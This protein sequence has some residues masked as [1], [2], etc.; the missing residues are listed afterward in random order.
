MT[1]LTYPLLIGGT[2]GLVVWLGEVLVLETSWCCPQHSPQ[3][4]SLKSSMR[5]TGRAMS[6]PTAAVLTGIISLVAFFISHSVVEVEGT[7]WVEPV[8]LWVSIGITTGSHHFS[9]QVPTQLNQ[10]CTPE[11]LWNTQHLVHVQADSVVTIP[12]YTGMVTVTVTAWW[13]SGITRLHW[14]DQLCP[15]IG[16]RISY[17]SSTFNLLY[18]ICMW[19]HLTCST[20]LP[21]PGDCPVQSVEE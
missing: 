21:A 20:W 15:V 7:D 11:I 1:L 14:I 17:M 5:S 3:L 6:V 13:T 2:T 19:K 12:G 4:P 9:I 16:V 8:L 18:N 10:M